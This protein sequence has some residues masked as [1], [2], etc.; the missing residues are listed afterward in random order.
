MGAVLRSKRR[1]ANS[2]EKAVELGCRDVEWLENEESF[3]AIRSE[4]RYKAII[5]QI[6]KMNGLKD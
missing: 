3:E 5:E 2:L 6:K 1:P 4:P